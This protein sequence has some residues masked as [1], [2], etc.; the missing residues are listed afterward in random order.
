MLLEKC[1]AVWLSSWRFGSL[2][3]FSIVLI[4]HCWVTTCSATII[5]YGHT[6]Y[7]P[8]EKFS[9]FFPHGFWCKWHLLKLCA[10][11]LCILLT[12]KILDNDKSTMWQWQHIISF[13][14]L[15]SASFLLS[16]CWRKMTVTSPESLSLAR[17]NHPFSQSA[18][19]G[20]N[21]MGWPEYL[22]DTGESCASLFCFILWCPRKDKKWESIVDCYV[23]LSGRSSLK[24]RQ[25][26]Q[27]L[28]SLQLGRGP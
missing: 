20:L 1:Q 6:G 15:L 23:Y 10:F 25:I 12:A 8:Q 17:R 9:G 4:S 14:H 27:C 21:C 28:L 19:T 22:P 7:R 2:E 13:L 16:Q 5:I 3:T 18:P 11:W 24:V 26:N